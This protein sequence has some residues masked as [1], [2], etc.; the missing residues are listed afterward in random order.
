V[1]SNQNQYL[2]DKICKLNILIDKLNNIINILEE[3][4]I[5]NNRI[6]KL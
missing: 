2:K 1:L 6:D 4:K 3:N 5:L